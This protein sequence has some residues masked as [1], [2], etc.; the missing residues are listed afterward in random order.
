MELRQLRYFIGIAE[1]GS[2]LK[3]SSRLH[4]AQPALGQQ[5]AALESELGTRLFVR[6]SRGM[7]LTDAGTT[8]L[9]HARIVLADVERARSV[10]KEAAAVPSGDVVIGLTNTIALAAT[11]PLVI[12]CRERL[13]QVRLKVVEAYSGFL[14]EWLQSGRLDLAFLFGDGEDPALIK[15]PLLEE[16]LALVTGMAG[17]ALPSRITLA[18]AARHPLVLPGREHGL[19]R[20]IDDAC[21]HQGI[22]LHVVA[23]IESLPSCKRA[24][25]AGLGATILSLGS[26][27][28]EVDAGRLR[29]A[30]ITDARML[31]RIV[32]AASVTRPATLAS[33]AVSDLACEV[34]KHK[35]QSGEWPARWIGA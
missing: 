16:H 33:R 31:R 14:R 5:M 28:E 20:I 11:L 19:R 3:A 32:I 4:V 9:D 13:P 27:A 8:F 35:V 30:T 34:V 18:R 22:E 12:A 2:L 7:S 1:A 23:E 10:V 25:E 6:S 29:A 21:T 17:P 15:R 24:V 26:V